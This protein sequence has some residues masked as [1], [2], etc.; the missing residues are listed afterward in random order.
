MTDQIYQLTCKK[1]ATVINYTKCL[2]WLCE[3]KVE[4]I[5]LDYSKKYVK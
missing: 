4:L 3:I 2:F 1:L 5:L